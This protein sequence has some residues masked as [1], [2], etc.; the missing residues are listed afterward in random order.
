MSEAIRRSSRLTFV[1]LILGLLALSLLGLSA[2]ATGEAE[3]LAL[4]RPQAAQTCQV[5][6]GEG[7]FNCNETGFKG[8]IAL[9]EVMY[10]FD[11][12]KEFVLNGASSAELKHEAIRLGMI[13]LRKAG[14][15]YLCEGV[16][17]VEEIVRVTAAD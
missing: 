10:M 6:K 15:H 17:T 4:D 16:T 14:L 2:C 8:R 3:A 1:P 9:D 13:T 7:C 11:D 12:L 5:H